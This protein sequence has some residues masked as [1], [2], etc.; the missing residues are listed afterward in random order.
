MI[1]VNNTLQQ[2]HHAIGIDEAGR[3][4]LC[5]PVCAAAIMLNEKYINR[6][7][8]LGV[9]D[10]KK[11]SSKKRYHIFEHLQEYHFYD[12]GLVDALEID[13]INIRQATKKAMYIAYENLRK[14][15]DMTHIHSIIIDG[16]FCPDIQDK[17]CYAI[18][19]GD[20]KFIEIAAASII[21][22][23]TRDNILKK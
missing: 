12:V 3:G 8:N 19:K 15:Y 14:R 4:P 1:M 5:G 18:V 17:D 7:I 22:K 13:M 9:H 2:Y 21:A 16:D 20:Q 23:V 11:L 10:S 6:L